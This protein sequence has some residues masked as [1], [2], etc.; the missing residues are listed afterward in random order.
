VKGLADDSRYFE[1][2]VTARA[3]SYQP[4]SF[5]N[6]YLELINYLNVPKFI[7]NLVKATKRKELIAQDRMNFGE[8]K[9]VYKDRAAGVSNRPQREFPHW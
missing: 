4:F 3:M 8:R 1:G 7:P 2:I 6:A 9:S 5:Q